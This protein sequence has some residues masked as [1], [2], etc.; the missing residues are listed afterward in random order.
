MRRRYA[1]CFA[2][3]TGIIPPPTFEASPIPTFQKRIS[4]GDSVRPCGRTEFG[5][6][7]GIVWAGGGG[8][9]KRRT[10]RLTCARGATAGPL[11]DEC[12]HNTRPIKGKPPPKEIRSPLAGRPAST[13]RII[14]P[15][16]ATV[17]SLRACGQGV[18]AFDAGRQKCRVS[19]ARQGSIRPGCRSREMRAA[20]DAVR[21]EPRATAI[22]KPA[23]GE[24][25]TVTDAGITDRLRTGVYAPSRTSARML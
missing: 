15:G 14:A 11:S 10:R 23:L 21:V 13:T 25:H 5:E 22:P 9:G 24:S 3:D 17:S 12:N 20:R 8:S 4:R 19:L 16:W 6:S 2:S 18:Y 1:Q 7:F